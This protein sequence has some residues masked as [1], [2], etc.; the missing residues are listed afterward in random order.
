[1]PCTCGRRWGASSHI[2]TRAPQWSGN[3]S[4]GAVESRSHP[5]PRVVFVCFAAASALQSPA[6]FDSLPPQ[7]RLS[8]RPGSRLEEQQT[9]NGPEAK[10]G[11]AGGCTQPDISDRQHGQRGSP[12]DSLGLR[13]D[14]WL[15]CPPTSWIVQWIPAQLEGCN[16]G[17]EGGLS[18]V[19]RL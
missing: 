6:Q 10:R 7:G 1:M 4:R 9:T 15:T 16:E 8:S 5:C 17:I 18:S 19:G 14:T 3:G 2:A 12:L 13:V 11:K